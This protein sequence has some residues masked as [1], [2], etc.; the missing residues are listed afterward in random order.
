MSADAST[1]MSRRAFLTNQVTR[2]KPTLRP[3]WTND[4]QV[5]RNCTSCSDCIAACPQDILTSDPRGRPHVALNGGECTFCQACAQACSHSVFDLTTSTPWP[6]QAEIGGGCLLAAGI[7]CQLCT[8]ICDASAL[9]MDLSAR[10]VGAIRIDEKACTGCGACLP[11]CPTQAIALTDAR[12]T[13]GA[14]DR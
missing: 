11:T 7:S 8:D 3:P 9:K 6:V 1:T 13:E 2:P 5:L 12:Q 10:P 14:H 4:A